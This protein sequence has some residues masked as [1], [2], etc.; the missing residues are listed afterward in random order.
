MKSDHMTSCNGFTLV[1]LLI[2]LAISG[3]LMTGVYT[4]FKSQQDSYLAQEQVAEMQQNIRAGLY[5]M[6]RDIRMAGFDP[7]NSLNAGITLATPNRF[8]FSRDTDGTGNTLEIITFGFSNA[9]DSDDDGIADAGSAPLGREVNDTG[10][11]QRVAE[12]I[13]ALEFRYLDRDGNVTA[14]LADIRSVQISILARAR[15]PDRN[16]TDSRTY[17]TAS[18]VNWGPFDD[19]FRRRFQ[20]ATV[21]LRNMGM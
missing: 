18:E 15:Q 8:G 16:Y 17:E 12:D 21:N 20:I 5:I 2:A 4:A 14:T 6:T 3:L 7:Q 10:G 11:F 9:N 19:N 13:H 1:E